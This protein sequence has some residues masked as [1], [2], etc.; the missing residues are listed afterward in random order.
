MQI[1]IYKKG[2][3]LSRKQ[4]AFIG[5][6]FLMIL[7][8]TILIFIY[9]AMF[10]TMITKRQDP[11]I[12]AGFQGSSGITDFGY[13]VNLVSELVSAVLVLG[14]L[15]MSIFKRPMVI[16]RY[17]VHPKTNILVEIMF[18]GSNICLLASDRLFINMLPSQVDIGTI[19]YPLALSIVVATSLMIIYLFGK[20]V[21]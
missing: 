18:L 17:H 1:P 19:I 3:I 13:G 16:G 12:G 15:L 14:W 11:L 8:Y 5:E 20:L 6:N 21:S 2:K 4:S 10:V 9:A 7:M